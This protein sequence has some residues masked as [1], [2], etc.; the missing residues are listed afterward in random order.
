MT[1]S[2]SNPHVYFRQIDEGERTS[3]SVL[4]HAIAPGSTILD[5]GCGSGALGRYLGE[6]KNCIADGVTYNAE[7]GAIAGA[8]YRKVAVADLETADLT[9]L[10]P[11]QQ[12]DYIVC[13]DV[14]EHLRAPQRILQSI[15]SMLKPG[16]ELLISIPNTAYAGLAAELVQ[17]E[18][19][20]RDEGLLDATHLR[21]FTRQSL[22]RFLGQAN[23]QVKNLEVIEREVV[24]SEFHLQ[25]DRM[26]PA[27]A[28]YFLSMPDALTYQFIVTAEPAQTN[29]EA[30]NARWL[31]TRHEDTQRHALFTAQ[32]YWRDAEGGS[33]D[34]KR[35]A[36]GIVGNERQCL[37]FD[38]SNLP[39]GIQQLRLDPADRPG[40]LRLFAMRLV[41]GEQTLWQ[42]DVQ[43]HGLA[44]LNQL[45]CSGIVWG[46]PW[47]GADNQAL[48]IL[49]D[50]D[51]WFVLPI[52]AEILALLGENR[53]EQ[54]DGP[55]S[56]QPGGAAALE[57]EL[58]WPM[59]ADYLALANSIAP[60]QQQSRLAL[61][62]KEQLGRLRL[63]HEH[64]VQEHRQL[65]LVASDHARARDQLERQAF[66]DGQEREYLYQSRQQA[67][68]QRD[69]YERELH[70]M[71]AHVRNLIQ[72]KPF[73]YTRTLAR[74]KNTLL[75]RPTPAPPLLLDP[76]AMA[77]SPVP[78][79]AGHAQAPQPMQPPAHPV[80]IIV[81]VYRGLS[82][83]QT[84]INS[85][86]ASPIRHAWRLIVI[87]DCSPE[88][89]VTQWLREKAQA[90][91]RII[92]LENEE[93]LGFVGTVNRG[94]RHSDANDVLLLNSDTEVANDWLDRIRAAAY[95]DARVASVTPF[96]NNATIC[97]YPH[98]CQ[99]NTLPPGQT[100]ARL[101]A[102]FA[103][104]NAGQVVDIPTGVG[105]CMYIRRDCLNDVGLFDQA[106]FGKGYGEEND[107][108]QR[109]IQKGWRNLHALDCFVLHTGGV[110]FKEHKSPR[111]IAAMETLR[112]LHPR[113]EADVMAFIQQDPARAARMAV[114]WALLTENG[115]RPVVLAVLHNR[116]GGTER[117]V[118]ELAQ[119]LEQDALFIT[120]KPVDEQR[121]AL[122]V[123]RNSAVDAQAPLQN[124]AIAFDLQHDYDAL[125]QLLRAMPVAH[126]HYHHLMGHAE[127]VWQLPQALGVGY[128]F[129]VHDFYPRCTNIT[130][131]GKNGH[132]IELDEHQE[133]CGGQHPLPSPALDPDIHAW[134]ARNRRLLQGARWVLA[135]SADAA[136]RIR[137]FAPGANVRFAPHTDIAAGEPLPA[138]APRKLQQGQPLRIAVIGALSVIKGADV[139]EDVARLAARNNAKVEFHLIGYGYRHLLTQ[140]RANLHVH[141]QYDEKDLPAMLQRIA[142]DL[143]WFPALW[144]ETYSYTLSAALL[145]GLPIAAPDL[146]A[147]AE[148]LHQRPWSWICPWQQTSAQWLDFFTRIKAAHFQ[149]Q[150]P[151]AQ[152]QA[153]EDR[154]QEM[155]G[156][157]WDYRSDYIKPLGSGPEHTSPV[158][159]QETSAIAPP[160]HIATRF[161]SARPVQPIAPAQGL[162]NTALQYLAR[163]RSSSALR[164]IARAIPKHWQTRCKNWLLG[165]R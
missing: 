19:L 126:V 143:V 10:F 115:Q 128:D 17:G 65:E 165:Q 164:P 23:W 79:A 78:V 110:S 20:Y 30:A 157:R 119:H 161:L 147:F 80:D 22:L 129:T 40:F 124:W 5:L 46:H 130:L 13:A 112:K 113:Y 153:P 140:P 139:L 95:S 70:G 9:A 106:H 136:L 118:L 154:L 67:I 18:F 109:A 81:P 99:D 85:V 56:L 11:G 12:Y 14:L 61:E 15:R 152:P 75:G 89:E 101:D 47:Q 45:E 24:D 90:E 34:R 31:H 43:E 116:A 88:P 108:C 114:D 59:S 21:H 159:Q 125:V 58:G 52:P 105:F 16:G 137:Q 77:A 163:L 94:M 145:A 138:P 127:A 111:E 121:V 72:S 69:Y 76:P 162:R 144:P 155:Q 64:L 49:T 50:D 29:T 55:A 57:V 146:G 142:P 2:Y 156:E 37:R 131:T 132:Y 73:R 66:L 4:V 48:A 62:L 122:Q 7:E 6:R 141:G 32:L 97:S 100:T 87:N 39:A 41:Q 25:F 27:V 134:R 135:P 83:T 28:R 1:I 148:R 158:Q 150:T 38:L 74:L 42:W 60:Y 44:A 71:A 51:P 82:D 123:L 160:A 26:P 107:F 86:L 84:C 63:E 117:H 93:N 8:Y 54:P 120:L 133:C 103:Q 33:E 36:H 35:T 68:T 151:P 92:L 104:A 98:F 53:G 91:P 102:L 149:T 96:S 3:L